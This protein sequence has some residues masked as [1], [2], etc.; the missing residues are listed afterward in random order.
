MLHTTYTT[1]RDIIKKYGR[2]YYRATFLFP[3]SI[4]EATWTYY[5]FVRTADEC[6]DDS[7]VTNHQKTLLEWKDAWIQAQ[8]GKETTQLFKKYS[9]ILTQYRI[10]LEYTH[11]FLDSMEQDLTV[12]RYQSYADLEA[13]MYGSAVVVGYTM[14][15]IIG[16]QEGALPYAKALAEA[17]QMTNFLRDVKEDYDARGRIYIPQ[18]DMQRFGV[19]EEM[20]AHGLCTPEWQAL[21]RFEIA[22]TRALYE[23]GV[24][25]ISYLD[26]QGR[27]A[28]YA[29]AL[30]YDD[31]LNTIERNNYDVFTKRAIVSPFRKTVLLLKAVWKRNQ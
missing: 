28:V 3:K 10:P 13:Y 26:A 19:T 18:E 17:F 2:G 24:A 1:A 22:R 27:K 6:V 20:V 16:F 21:M 29:A 23:K 7:T 8:C 12:T 9:E 5:E 14:S 4:R 15:H 30:I 11:A 31:I 25:G